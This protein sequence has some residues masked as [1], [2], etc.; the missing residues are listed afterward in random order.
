MRHEQTNLHIWCTM[1]EKKEAVQDKNFENRNEEAGLQVVRTAIKTM[2]RGGGSMDF[3]ADLDLL[4][5]TPG[6]IYAVK[7]NS[8][9]MYFD[10]RDSTFEVVTPMMQK[11]FRENVNNITVSLDKVTV[12]HT[13]YTVIVTYFF[14]DGKLHVV[15]NQLTILKLED[16]DSEGTARMVVDTLTS[17]LGYSRTQLANRL[18]HFSYDGVY[19]SSEER[20]AGGGCLSL[21]DNVT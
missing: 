18:R 5:L 16:Y 12:H 4:S 3:M 15:M 19:A 2:K 13:S 17:T 7:N 14:W 21:V 6:V 8:R 9:T 11:F 10:L 20:V 1:K